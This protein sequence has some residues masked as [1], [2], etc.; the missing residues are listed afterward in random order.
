[1]L[2]RPPIYHFVRRRV[3]PSLSLP[4][5]PLITINVS[6]LFVHAQSFCASLSLLYINIIWSLFAFSLSLFTYL[7]VSVH[8][9]KFSS[10][11]RR[12]ACYSRGPISNEWEREFRVSIWSG[13]VSL[14]DRTDV[15]FFFQKAPV[16]TYFLSFFCFLKSG[17]W[18]SL[19]FGEEFLLSLVRGR[20]CLWINK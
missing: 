5:P 11:S 1:M 19:K 17:A 9:S 15:F 20:I 2:T 7:Q 6:Q 13:P 8:V 18:Y 4:L 10:T 14:L 12:I 16:L 3:K